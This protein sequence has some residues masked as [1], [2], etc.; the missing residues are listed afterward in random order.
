MGE[1]CNYNVI[2]NKIIT[3]VLTCKNFKNDKYNV[4]TCKKVYSVK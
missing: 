2:T 4:K 3:D 1:Q